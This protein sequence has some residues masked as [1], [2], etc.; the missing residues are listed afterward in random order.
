MVDSSGWR[1]ARFPR[2]APSHPGARNHEQVPLEDDAI[3]RRS[4]SRT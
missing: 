2:I 4:A 1:G 3:G